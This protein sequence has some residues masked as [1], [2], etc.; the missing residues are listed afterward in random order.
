[1][2]VPPL[3][4]VSSMVASIFFYVIPWCWYRYKNGGLVAGDVLK[5]TAHPTLAGSFMVALSTSAAVTAVWAG[6]QFIKAQLNGGL[7]APPLPADVL[8]LG[9]VAFLWISGITLVEHFSTVVEPK[10]RGKEDD[11]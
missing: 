1:M 11:S 3:I 9:V 7:K 5:D 8:V 10:S 2:P 4:I 6:F